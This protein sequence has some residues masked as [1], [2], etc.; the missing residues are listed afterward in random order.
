MNKN[1]GAITGVTDCEC[2]PI[3]DMQRKQ[4][5]R[6][7]HQHSVTPLSVPDKANKAADKSCTPFLAPPAAAAADDDDDND[8]P[9]TRNI[10]SIDASVS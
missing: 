9:Q 10:E 3:L 5:E 1:C 6:H 8:Q 2:V 4:Q 7:T